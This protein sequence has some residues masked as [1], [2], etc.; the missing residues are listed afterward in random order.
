MRAV[1]GQPQF[2]VLRLFARPTPA[3]RHG[4]AVANDRAVTNFSI[5]PDDTTVGALMK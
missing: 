5:A 4:T 1:A 2:A 3:R